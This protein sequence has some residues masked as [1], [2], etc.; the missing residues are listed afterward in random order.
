MLDLVSSTMGRQVSVLERQNAAALTCSS[1][2]PRV[3]GSPSSRLALAPLLSPS[4]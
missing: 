3:A 4:A 1:E 2:A